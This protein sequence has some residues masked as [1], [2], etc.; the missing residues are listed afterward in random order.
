MVKSRT[1]TGSCIELG[2]N[3]QAQR[4]VVENPE[5]KGAYKRPKQT[6]NNIN[7]DLEGM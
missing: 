4:A 1:N 5:G 7:V 3:I 2:E 6:W